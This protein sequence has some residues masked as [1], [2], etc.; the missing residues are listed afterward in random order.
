MNEHGP[1][2]LGGGLLKSKMEHLDSGVRIFKTKDYGRFNMIAGNRLLDE[3]KIKR[4]V[5]DCRRGFN[6]LSHCPLICTERNGRLDIVD[7]QHRFWVAK[8]IKDF[9][10]YV[11]HSRVA[12]EDIARLNTCTAKWTSRDYIH[13]YA[14]QNDENYI[15][16]ERFMEKWRLSPTTAI[17]L[18]AQGRATA[19]GTKGSSSNF[20]TGGFEVVYAEK[21]EQIM[22][23][24]VKFSD[25]PHYRNGPFLA[26]IT[27]VYE[28][29]WDVQRLIG[30][31][32]ENPARLTKRATAKDY[33]T[34]LALIYSKTQ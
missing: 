5:Q 23:L 27:K 15:S 24:A 30:R 22:E 7:G 6:L 19:G 20:R 34:L 9:V 12:L 14:Q 32:M 1:A 10:F 2:F 18:L 11:L 17:Q 28:E 21:A 29:K 16:L 25:F 4:I 13:C 8:T 31:Y 3:K 33:E 26:A